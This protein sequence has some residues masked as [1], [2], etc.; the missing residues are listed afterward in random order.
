MG[1]NNGYPGFL[2]LGAEGTRGF[3]QMPLAASAAPIQ[4]SVLPIEQCLCGQQCLVGQRQFL[5]VDVFFG[6]TAQQFAL[7]RVKP[8]D[9]CHRQS[10]HRAN[11]PAVS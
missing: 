1:L 5:V 6:P 2:N 4:E 3:E 10:H 9:L 8:W 7:P 11:G